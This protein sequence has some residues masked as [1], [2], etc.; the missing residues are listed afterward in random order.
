MRL[1]DHVV[2]VTGGALRLGQAIACHLA[3]L[4]A[5]VAVHH[6]QSSPADTLERIHIAGGRAHAFAADFTNRQQVRDL[7][8][9]VVSQLGRLD[10]LVNSAAIFP[11]HDTWDQADDALW[12]A[13]MAVNLHAPFVLAQ[14][15]A[16][17]LPNQ[18]TGRIVNVTD[19]RLQRPRPDHLVYRLA[20]QG[21][22]TLTPMLAQALAP[23][24]AVN[25]LALGA[26]LPPPGRPQS[27]LDALVQARV[28]LQRAGNA[29]LVAEAVAYLLAHPF[30]TGATLT[31]D[32]GEFL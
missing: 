26:I 18:A 14:A 29:P 3:A 21:L 25:A 22:Q 2:L 31:L 4:G 1:D 23:R 12:D 24:I 10:A 13:V 20:K 7:V 27:D 19:A 32:G 15:F 6:G 11:A 16:R 5:T 9:Q 8:P 17:Q 30:M 28:P